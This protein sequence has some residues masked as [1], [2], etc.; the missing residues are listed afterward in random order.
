[1]EDDSTT[2]DTTSKSPEPC[3]EALSPPTACI[4]ESPRS[5][6]SSNEESASVV[7]SDHQYTQLASV[8]V[9]PHETNKQAIRRVKNNAAS[10]VCRRQRK[11]RLTTNIDKM[12]ELTAK[13]RELL[14]KIAEA[15]SVVSLLK[16]H[17]IKATCKK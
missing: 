17:L 4:I 3:V 10:R 5:S 9:K 16:N 6:V 7:S 8:V 15:E 1:M 13:N 12:A 14:A 11:N 2:A